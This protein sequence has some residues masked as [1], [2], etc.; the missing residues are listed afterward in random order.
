MNKKH[1][2]AAI[3]GSLA[4][5]LGTA[6]AAN[7]L[8]KYAQT[9][10]KTCVYCHTGATNSNTI[11]YRG[12]FYK[13]NKYTFAGFDDAAEAKKAGV[14]VG[15]DAAPLPKSYSA[16]KAD[17]TK[18]AEETAKPA[19]ETVKPAGEA[20]AKP[21]MA[22]PKPPKGTLPVAQAT[23]K[24][25]AA[26]KAHLAAPRNAARKKAF[27]AAVAQLG[28]AT[29][30]APDLRPMEK[31]PQALRLYRQ[32]LS[33]DP[34]NSVALADKKMIEGVYKSMGRPVPK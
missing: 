5:V 8:P 3:V 22:Q 30:Y 27:A 9:E 1:C 19:E 18:P 12:K 31:Y 28:R 17:D 7:A 16:P 26:E 21:P 29:M 13:Q 24:F 33:L 14:E 4:G 23:L 2:L 15:P 20:A 34:K 25:K 10:G 32:A 11:N 6:G